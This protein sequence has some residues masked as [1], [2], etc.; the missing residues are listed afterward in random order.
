MWVNSWREIAEIMGM[1]VRE[2]TKKWK[3]QRDKYVFQNDHKEHDHTV[4]YPWC[5]DVGL[6][7]GSTTGSLN[8]ALDA[9]AGMQT[10]VLFL[11]GHN[12][13]LEFGKAMKQNIGRNDVHI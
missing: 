1:D 13:H 4:F 5:N 10:T 9:A 11:K 12:L 2:W 7:T 6:I 3:K 8:E